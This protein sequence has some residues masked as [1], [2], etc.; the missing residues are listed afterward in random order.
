[1]KEFFNRLKKTKEIENIVWLFSD[2][3][4]RIIFGLF[5]WSWL[6]RNLSKEYFG[7][8]GF[9]LSYFNFFMPFSNLGLQSILIKKF[10]TRRNDISIIFWNAIFLIALGS[11]CCF[12]LIIYSI[13]WVLPSDYFTQSI[14]S[15]LSI[16]ILF[17]FGEISWYYFESKV[18]SR[19]I[20]RIQLTCFVIFTVLKVAIT[21]IYSSLELLAWMTISEA[22]IIAFWSSYRLKV[23]DVKIKFQIPN[24]KISKILLSQS[25][26]LML[27]GIAIMIYMR[28]DQIMIGK[29]KNFE[30]VAI[31]T[32]AI[33]ISEVW[34]FIP[35][36]ISATF[37]PMLVK[38]KSNEFNFNLNL[39][40]LLTVNTAI[41]IIIA[42]L[43]SLF[44]HS[45]T[46]TLFGEEYRISGTI[47]SIHI[48]ALIFVSIG[49]TGGNW[50]IIKNYQNLY[51]IRTL[52]GAC[53]NI[54]L[55]IVLIPDLGAIGAAIA[56]VISYGFSAFISDLFSTRTHH[57]FR[58][59]MNSLNFFKIVPSLKILRFKE[60]E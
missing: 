36:I 32:T 29:L 60:Y 23:E 41:S 9:A 16:A 25:V 31:Y 22:I 34:Y 11:F 42:I 2:K 12:L 3:I 28:I 53:L 57:L 46:T 27:S 13:K 44:S 37:F 54:I 21:S 58:M 47:L 50:F 39:Q 14:V 55:N 26:P 10:V 24:L 48:W 45:I 1:M 49:V 30:E 15:I 33:K 52:V 4:I 20:I 51:L 38:K 6:A 43:I 35:S 19:F 59:K 7:I 17:K 5:F 18:Q 8:L 40:A 56:T